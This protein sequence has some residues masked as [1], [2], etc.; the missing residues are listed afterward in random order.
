[1]S[2]I[3]LFL[4]FFQPFEDLFWDI[5][6]LVEKDFFTNNGP[7]LAALL[8]SGFSFLTSIILTDKQVKTLI[9]TTDSTN[10]TNIENKRYE[11]NNKNFVELFTRIIEEL[12]KII[13]LTNKFSYYDKMNEHEKNI[14]VEKI[15]MQKLLFELLLLDEKLD[16]MKILLE[17][18]KIIEYIKNIKI[19]T[20]RPEQ[21]EY[22]LYMS[23][24]FENIRIIL[25][26]RWNE[27]SSVSSK[28]I[29]GF[30]R[31]II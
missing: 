5:F 21:N 26:K 25:E 23:D 28:N 4:C 11:I 31:N 22:T 29:S 8:I 12:A 16:K 3:L 13:D 27:Q 30:Q 19:G 9:K 10:L 20:N 6:N 18:D 14:L 15:Q 2:V 7:W 17:T 1:M 24:C